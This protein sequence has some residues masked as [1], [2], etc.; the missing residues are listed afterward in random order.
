MAS[1]NSK[2]IF[3]QV[4]YPLPIEVNNYASKEEFNISR[5]WEHIESLRKLSD[6]RLMRT[7]LRRARFSAAKQKPL[8][9]EAFEFILYDMLFLDRIIKWIRRNNLADKFRQALNYDFLAEFDNPDTPTLT[10]VFDLMAKHGVFRADADIAVHITS[11]TTTSTE[12]HKKY[13]VKEAFKSRNG[14][15]LI[16]AKRI[17]AEGNTIFPYEEDIRQVENIKVEDLRKMMTKRKGEDFPKTFWDACQLKRGD[18][19]RFIGEEKKYSV[20]MATTDMDN[21]NFRLM[22]KAEDEPLPKIFTSDQLKASQ[23]RKK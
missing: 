8:H 4:Y 23:N 10:E 5:Y 19:V 9:T 6:I 12:Y 16:S 18:K 2:S 14:V 1:V 21:F 15:W 17:N 3:T 7:L 20:I 13:R 11:P 22:C